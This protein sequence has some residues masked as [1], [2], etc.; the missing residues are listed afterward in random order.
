VNGNAIKFGTVG[1]AAVTYT[2]RVSGNTM[3]GVYQVGSSAHGTWKAHRT[4]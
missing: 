1:S 3:A 4:S 2:G